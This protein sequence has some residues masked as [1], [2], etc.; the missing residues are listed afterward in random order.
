MKYKVKTGDTLW[1]LARKYDTT[2]EAI[3]EANGMSGTTIYVGETIEIPVG[4]K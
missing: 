1:A 4:Q 3:Q 2:V